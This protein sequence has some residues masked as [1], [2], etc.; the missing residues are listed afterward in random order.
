M[1]P[2]S[3]R[4]VRVLGK[5]DDPNARYDRPTVDNVLARTGLTVQ[6]F[7]DGPASSNKKKYAYVLVGYLN[8]SQL[9][10]A[11]KELFMKLV[12]AD[13]RPS[14]GRIFCAYV[15]K[16]PQTRSLIAHKSNSKDSTK[17]TESI[18]PFVKVMDENGSIKSYFVAEFGAGED[19]EA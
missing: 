18:S 17:K 2:P 5:S 13:A 8:L 1:S 6:P 16:G 11:G 3:R 7:P 14:D 12:G 19:N 15:G 10:F 9:D 4:S